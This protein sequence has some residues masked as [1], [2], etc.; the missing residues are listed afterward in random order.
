MQ[1]QLKALRQ[2]QVA[3]IATGLVDA[4]LRGLQKEARIRDPARFV[5]AN[6]VFYAHPSSDEQL[7]SPILDELERR[8]GNTSKRP[9]N[10]ATSDPI[11]RDIENL[12]PWQLERVQVTWTPSVRRFPTEFAY[13]H[14]GAVLRLA[15]G[16][17]LI[18]HEDLSQVVYP[19]QRYT[20]PMRLGIYFFGTAPQDDDEE[21]PPPP[22]VPE[23]DAQAQ[24][25]VP[26]HHHRHLV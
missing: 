2:N 18:E 21:P 17:I 4:I 11:Y 24:Q 10:I 15:N 16:K 12:I 25:R 7:W 5:K 9:Y 20:D 3:T 26:R 23:A 6:K 14:R 1:S 8:F 19:K 13:T 22:E